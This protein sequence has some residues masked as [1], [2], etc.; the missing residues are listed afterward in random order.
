MGDRYFR[1]DVSFFHKNTCHALMQKLGPGGPLTFLALLARAKD[2]HTPGTF[3]YA[4]DAIGWEK[5]GLEPDD[6][7]FTLDEFFHAT[8]RLKQTSRRRHG[9][10][11]N[12]SITRYERWQQESER[13]E[14]AVRKSRSRGKTTRDKA[15]TAPG[16]DRDATMDLDLG[17]SSTPLPPI[18]NG[19]QED[20]KPTVEENLER[21]NSLRQTIGLEVPAE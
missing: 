2:G 7:G 6:V 20:P 13:Y 18:L 15:V 12:V 11:W 5:L 1:V 19:H 16:H 21:L 9:R 3:S 10:V 17:S 8:G 14:A 4:S